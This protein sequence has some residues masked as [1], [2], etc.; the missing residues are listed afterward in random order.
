MIAVLKY[1][2]EDIGKLIG[3]YIKTTTSIFA[4][5]GSKLLIQIDVNKRGKRNKNYNNREE[6]KPDKAE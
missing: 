6:L 3:F 5:L 2:S 1:K 4:K